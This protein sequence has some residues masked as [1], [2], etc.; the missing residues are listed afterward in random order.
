MPRIGTFSPKI[1]HKGLALVLLPIIAESIFFWQLYGLVESAE[2]LAEAEQRQS[3]F[4]EKMNWVMTLFAN[5]AG[6]MFS[7]VI[8]GRQAYQMMGQA[9]LDGVRKEFELMDAL[10]GDDPRIKSS[11]EEFRA[12]SE[13]EFKRLGSFCPPEPGR[14]YSQALAGLMDLKPYLRQAGAKSRMVMKVINGQREY[15][16]EVRKKQAQTRADV[17]K[18]VF[19]GIIGNFL[20]AIVLVLIFIRNITGRLAILV[21]NARLLPAGQRLRRHVMGG[22]ELAYL[23]NALH[24][25]ADELSK[26]AEQRQLLMEMVAHDLRSPLMSSQVALEI[27]TAEKMVV[28]LPPPAVRQVNSVKRNITRLVALSNDLLTLDKLEAGKLELEYQKVDLQ[29]TVEE[30]VQ[31][32]AALAGQKEIVLKNNC[33]PQLVHVDKARILQVLVNYLSNAIKFSPDKGEIVVFSGRDG[34]FDE[35]GVQGGA[36]TVSVLDQGPGLSAEDQAKLFDKYFQA[37]DGQRS[38]GF[39]LGLAICKLIVESHGGK[40]G[41]D[42]HVGHGSRFWFSLPD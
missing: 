17:K 10:V 28:L 13:D 35:D 11:L 5:A 9:Y 8:T 32:V 26:A 16:E 15:L 34:A 21:E 37:N 18:F 7:Y 19:A 25:A 23:D 41:V 39:G 2:R 12:M 36:V 27:L 1:I 3:A 33:Q 40:V 20:L 6:S 29:A 30:A 31:S 42:S 4:V 38:K 24:A 14:T 22:D